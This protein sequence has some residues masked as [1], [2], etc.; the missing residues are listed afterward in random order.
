MD[1]GRTY[2]HP[3]SGDLSRDERGVPSHRPSSLTVAVWALVVLLA[4]LLLG[5]GCVAFRAQRM[6]VTAG[7]VIEQ[8]ASRVEYEPLSKVNDGSYAEEPASGRAKSIGILKR[9]RSR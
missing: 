1:N 4:A 2:T 8:A 3:L 9:L 5:G 6:A 7:K